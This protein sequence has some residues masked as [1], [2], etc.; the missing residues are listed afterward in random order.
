MTTPTVE[1]KL[2][3]I[4]YELFKLNFNY[5]VKNNTQKQLQVIAKKLGEKNV[6]TKNKKKLNKEELCIMI[7]K[8]KKFTLKTLEELKNINKKDEYENKVEYYKK[9][10]QRLFKDTE[11]LKNIN[12]DKPC[13]LFKGNK[14]IGVKSKGYFKYVVSYCIYNNIF[15][16]DLQR[17]NEDGERMDICHG[18]NCAKKCIEPTHLSL[19]TKS[20]NNYEDKI[21]DGTLMRG[22]KNSNAKITEKIALQIKH[23]KGDGRT[24]KERARDFGV[25]RQLIHNIDLNYTWF[26]LPDKDGTINYKTKRN[27]KKDK[28][29]TEKNKK[30]NL[31][32][33]N[34]QL[35]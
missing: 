18:H 5:L 8:N 16:E 23:S 14:Q 24:Q 30:K 15:V 19:K 28:K 25:S 22:E 27:I 35:L 33:K 13:L 26:Y 1:S 20:E 10:K 29:T 3:N 7:L 4:N 12:Y 11:E 9:L 32:K 21:R 31:Q 2:S 17:L 34:G 6:S